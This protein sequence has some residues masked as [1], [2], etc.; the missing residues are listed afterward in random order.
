MEAMEHIIIV[1][2]VVPFRAQCDTRRDKAKKGSEN[3][4]SDCQLAIIANTVIITNPAQ[5]A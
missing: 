4:W 5:I 2:V 1:V 3:N